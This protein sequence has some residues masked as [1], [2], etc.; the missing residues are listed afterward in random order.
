[1]SL[2]RRLRVA[3]RY[4]RAST[5]GLLCNL[6]LMQTSTPI[7]VDSRQQL[8]KKA[9]SQTKNGLRGGRHD[10]MHVTKFVPPQ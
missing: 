10:R 2:G 1:M 4:M 7:R 5:V 9:C 6:F 3:L 8:D